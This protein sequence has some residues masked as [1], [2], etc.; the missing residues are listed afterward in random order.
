MKKLIL[1]LMV[2]LLLSSSTF[3]LANE[4]NSELSET[5]PISK[6]GGAVTLQVK[7]FAW[8]GVSIKEYLS[9]RA[10]V[11]NAIEK[12]LEYGF[13]PKSENLKVGITWGVMKGGKVINFGDATYISSAA[14]DEEIEGVLIPFF[15]KLSSNGK[16]T[17]FAHGP[18]SISKFKL[19]VSKIESVLNLATQNQLN[20]ILPKAFKIGIS[21][22]PMKGGKLIEFG[23]V[24]Y[25]DV[26]A[27]P[28]EIERHLTKYIVE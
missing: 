21:G 25:L 20:L 15:T 7:F 26:S 1:G 6:E 18:I 27:S 19:G 13:K 17:F 10:R 16:I 4:V 5:Y 24:L 14:S 9:G 2:G 8:G 3:A 11:R 12:L 23:V 22:L 28:E